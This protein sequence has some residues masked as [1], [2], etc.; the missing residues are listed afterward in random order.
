MTL[1]VMTVTVATLMIAVLAVYLFMIGGLLNR[2][3]DNLG[4]CLQNLRAVV[5]QATV[6]SPGVTR[7][8]KTGEELLGALPLLLEDVDGVAAKLAPS[9]AI[10]EPT[11]TA[12]V[13]APAATQPS[14]GYLDGHPTPDPHPAPAKGVG[15]MDS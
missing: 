9:A 8:N 10:Q 12:A 4:D 2:T 14:V 6:I 3:A 11:S 7:L 5:G 1:I 15:Y 13:T